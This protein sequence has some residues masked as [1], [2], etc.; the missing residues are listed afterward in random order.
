MAEDDLIYCTTGTTTGSHF[1]LAAAVN[2]MKD[3]MVKLPPPDVLMMHPNTYDLIRQQEEWPKTKL[4]EPAMIL[5]PLVQ[6]RDLKTEWV[7]PPAGRF[8]ELTSEDEEWAEPLGLGTFR[9]VDLGPVIYRI[10]QSVLRQFETEVMTVK[11]S[12]LAH[13]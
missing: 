5:S 3:L 11:P 8:T 2:A 1:D 9:T 7:P 12:F 4:F 6:E 10:N 13:R